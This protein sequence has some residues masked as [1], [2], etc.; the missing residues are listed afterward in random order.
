MASERGSDG[1][2]R[3]LNNVLAG[4]RGA[5]VVVAAASPAVPCLTCRRNWWNRPHD[6]GCPKFGG[7]V[8]R[9]PLCDWGERGTSDDDLARCKLCSEDGDRPAWEW[10]E[11]RG[12][13]NL[14][15][16]PDALAWLNG[17]G[18]PAGFEAVVNCRATEC[19]GCPECDVI[20]EL[21]AACPCD[22][23]E[24]CAA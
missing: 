21:P 18:W 15:L 3:A 17:Y 2:N 7:S 9:C 22:G 4:P 19:E 10:G 13:I 20:P 23:T 12:L 6:A 11:S 1:C 14:P 5:E 24:H 8:M 16:S